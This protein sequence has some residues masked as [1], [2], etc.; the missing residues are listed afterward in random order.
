MCAALV[1]TTVFT[2]GYLF[3]HVAFYRDAFCSGVSGD[4]VFGVKWPFALANLVRP[5]S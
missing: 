1:P 2:Y 3:R 5:R 4:G